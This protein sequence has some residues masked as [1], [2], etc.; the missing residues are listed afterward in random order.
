[1]SPLKIKI[2]SKNM[3]EMYGS[4]S[5]IPSKKTLRLCCVEGFNSGIKGLISSY[6]SLANARPKVTTVV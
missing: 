5:K 2:P 3:C 4:R 6:E 1:V